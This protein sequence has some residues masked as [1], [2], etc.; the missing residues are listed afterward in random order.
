MVYY[1][2]WFGKVA[3]S[4]RKQFSGC[5]Q[6]FIKSVGWEKNFQGAHNNGILQVLE[7]NCK[8]YQKIN[9]Q[10]AHVLLRALV[11]K[12]CKKYMEIIFKEAQR[13]QR[14]RASLGFNPALTTTLNPEECL[15]LPWFMFLKEKFFKTN[16]Q[17]VSHFPLNN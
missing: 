16:P 4:I 6:Q 9:F 15:Y 17:L 12:S 1:K 11:G 5:P 10:G 13:F 2:C 8:K 14:L 7:K 3:K